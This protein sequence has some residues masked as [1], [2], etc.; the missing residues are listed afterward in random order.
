MLKHYAPFFYPLD[1][2]E[3]QAQPHRVIGT[4]FY[5]DLISTQ[6][7]MV[8]IEHILSRGVKPLFSGKRG[9]GQMIRFNQ[10]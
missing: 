7:Y 1:L 4:Q 6:G 9:R 8:G 5:A 3:G 10:I 2:L